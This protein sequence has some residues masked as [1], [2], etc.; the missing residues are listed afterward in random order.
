MSLVA[1][2]LDVVEELG[3]PAYRNIVVERLPNRVVLVDP[4]TRPWVEPRKESSELVNT[5]LSAPRW[6]FL[7]VLDDAILHQQF[8]HGEALVEGDEEF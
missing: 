3:T 8:V 1:I 5:I 6:F 2:S 4:V 7:R